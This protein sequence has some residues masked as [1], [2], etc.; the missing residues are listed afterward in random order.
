MTVVVVSSAGTSGPAGTGWLSGVGPPSNTL[1][2]N[3]DFYLDTTNTG[4]Y[5][6]PKTAG[7]WGA[8]NQFT[9]LKSNP[10]ATVNPTPNDDNTLGYVVGSFWV[11][12]TGTNVY[13]VAN[14]VDTG[15]AVWV[16]VL[17]VGVISGTVAAGNDSRIVGALQTG[18]AAAGDLGG[19]YPNPTVLST[20]LTVPLP[21]VQGGTGS[22][23]Q[24]FVDLTT[25]QSI[26]GLKNFTGE[27]EVPTPI[28]PLDAATKEYVDLTSSGG[29]KIHASVAAGTTVPLP[30][31][32]YN[33][34]TSG[35][36]ATLTANAPGVLVLDG[37]TVLLS[38]RVLIKNEVA[39]ENNG[40]YD[41]TTLGT[42][43]VPYVL[44]RSIDL[45]EA[46][47]IPGSFTFISNG[48][49]LAT[50]GWIV[51]GSGP[52][53]IGTTPINWTQGTGATINAGT[54][55]SLVGNVMSLI[56][57]VSAANLPTGS[58]SAFGIVEF[59]NNPVV[60]N[61]IGTA[62]LGATGKVADAGHVHPT[63]GVVLMTD[64]AT[65]V[66]DGTS[67]GLPTVVGTDTTYAREDHSHGTPIVSNTAPSVVEAIGTAASAGIGST[68]SRSD[69]VHPMSVAG[70]PGNSAPGDT[71]NTGGAT[72]FA[73][74]D[75]MHGREGFGTV[76][77]ELTYGQS[78]TSGT[79]TTVSHSDHTHG[80]PPLTNTAPGVTEG[81]GTV[82]SVGVS[83]T[84]ARDDH[85]HPM[86]AA[87]P[88][89]NSAVTDTNATGAATTFA[90]SNHVHGR[91]GFGAVTALS[92]F[93]TPSATGTASTVSHSDHVHGAPSLPSATT[94]VLGVVQ[95]AGDLGGTAT[96]PSVLKINGVTV[97]GTPAFGNAIRATTASAASWSFLP[98][99]LSTGILTGAVMTFNAT[100]SFNLS[101]GT[102]YIAD[103]V[104]TPATPTVQQV[105]IASQVVTLTGGA[106]TN[107]VNYWYADSTGT[108]QTQTTP[109]TS[110]Q[111][112]QNIDLGVTWSATGTGVI[113]N[114]IS[115][116]IVQN[117]PAPTRNGLAEALGTVN[118]S[119]NVVSA[120]G[121]NLNINKT[122]GTIFGPGIGYFQNGANNPDQVTS[123]LETAAT[124]RYVTQLTNSESATRT[125]LDVA[126]IDVGGTITPLTANGNAGVHRVWLLPTAVAGAQIIIQY[127]QAQYTNLT[128]ADT[129][130][131]TENFVINPDL[132]NKA[133]LI[134]YIAAVKNAT[135]LTNAAQ[136]MFNFAYRLSIP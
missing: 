37:Y 79:A 127:G 59:N 123:P 130:H 95:L 69:H 5:Y 46:S 34:G 64:A 103:Y 87:A 52:F 116:A 40:I 7:V 62:A 27:I 47:E 110:V 41:V 72:T 66:T 135:Q 112:R 20:S 56:V 107:V 19:T 13:F 43:S 11:N 16:P 54:G 22:S 88:P 85:V 49:T 80:T 108:V 111:K 9:I 50:T 115:A 83:L 78:S 65:T 55:L 26:G 2:Q 3:G 113:Y 6:G 67:Y 92:A 133:A 45:D 74:S 73:A 17:P 44:T 91:E 14:S 90:S 86:A 39:A 28:N 129:N 61:P 94:G 84:P 119:G 89:T 125:T 99:F 75:H 118:V 68:P 120:N 25:T 42:V 134:G 128:T 63:D 30:A 109:L 122:A 97:S 132:G 101:A 131:L 70:V 36:G 81:I 51:V 77:T 12:T 117:Q 93:N 100:N 8:P 57:P 31:S 53:V 102:A 60:I 4:V 96:S 76:V 18:A 35:V 82:A 104:T 126:N 105:N 124:F 15:A 21:V 106:L 38:D 136:A 121:A 10:F 1:G 32:T 98:N 33:N 48:S 58:T 71:A 23:L 24:N 114:I 29:L